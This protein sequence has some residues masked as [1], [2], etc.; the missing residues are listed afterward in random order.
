[1]T[2]HGMVRYSRMVHT[3]NVRL[4][5]PEIEGTSSS[6]EEDASRIKSSLYGTVRSYPPIIVAVT[7]PWYTYTVTDAEEDDALV[8]AVTVKVYMLSTAK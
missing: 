3:L 2:W 6:E 5:L 4:D 8:L 7:L 1:M